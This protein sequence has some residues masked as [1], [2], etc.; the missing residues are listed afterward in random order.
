MLEQYEA[1]VLE[2]RARRVG[3]TP[4]A[5]T[6]EV[7]SSAVNGRTRTRNANAQR[8]ISIGRRQRRSSKARGSTA[9]LAV[10]KSRLESRTSCATMP[11]TAIIPINTESTATSDNTAGPNPASR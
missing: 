10:R 3:G 6:S 9:A 1:V 11:M 8:A 4:T 2:R 5:D 7:R